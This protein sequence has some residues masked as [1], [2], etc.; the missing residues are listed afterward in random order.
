MEI[1]KF[2]TKERFPN[3]LK[4]FHQ[5]PNELHHEIYSYIICDVYNSL[6]YDYE[7]YNIINYIGANNA[8]GFEYIMDKFN[9]MINDNSDLKITDGDKH[10]VGMYLEKVKPSI[11]GKRYI[12]F[13][14]CID[15][16]KASKLIC[17]KVDKYIYSNECNTMKLFNFNLDLL[18]L[19]EKLQNYDYQK[20]NNHWERNG[21]NY[22]SFLNIQEEIEKHLYKKKI[23]ILHEKLKNKKFYND[24]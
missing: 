11:W 12:Y 14:D 9:D 19:D 4:I 2:S 8:T 22:D 3:E 7:W 10:D 6:W 16:D 23:G 18:F 17:D 15:E 5:L 1:I 24:L 13:E 21:F 20:A